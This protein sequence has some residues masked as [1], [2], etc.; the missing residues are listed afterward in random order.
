[1]E[2]SR[3]NFWAP[4]SPLLPRLNP[5]CIS[6]TPPWHDPQTVVFT[7]AWKAV[8]YPSQ[9]GLGSVLLATRRHVSRMADLTAT[10][11]QDFQMVVMALE[12]ALE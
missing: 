5:T 7:D 10:E 2:A 6:C 4:A 1:M 3:G 9:A 11:W 12:P 8:L